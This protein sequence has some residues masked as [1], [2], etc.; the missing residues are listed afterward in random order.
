[1]LGWSVRLPASPTG[2]QRCASAL[3]SV[4]VHFRHRLY[5]RVSGKHF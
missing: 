2:D 3:G 1:M 4:G 5:D